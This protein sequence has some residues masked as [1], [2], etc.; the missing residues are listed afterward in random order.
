MS[1]LVQKN[2][3]LKRD[4]MSLAP[5]EADDTALL[6]PFSRS[7]VARLSS[8]ARSSTLR[9]IHRKNERVRDPLLL[10]NGPR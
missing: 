7:Y 5:I 6:S 8:S 2:T 9:L 4:A 3:V 1:E 10:L